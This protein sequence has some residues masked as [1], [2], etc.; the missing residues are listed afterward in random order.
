MKATRR[1][2]AVVVFATVVVMGV[3]RPGAAGAAEGFTDARGV[4]AHGIEQVALWGIA[5]GCGGGRFCPSDPISRAEMVT[6]LSKAA[7]HL[8]SV[9]APPPPNLHLRGR[10]SPT[11]PS[12][13]A[14]PR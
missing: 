2:A 5:E 13:E 3:L 12:P 14:M 4:H 11:G 10:D 9:Y 8:G 7:T 1:G 6:W